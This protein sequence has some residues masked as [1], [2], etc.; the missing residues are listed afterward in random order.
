MSDH[1]IPDSK[2]PQQTIPEIDEIE[3]VLRTYRPAP[4]PHLYTRIA[5]A[6]WMKPEVAAP[7]HRANIRQRVTY[8]WA[9]AFLAVLLVC[10]FMLFTSP[11]RSLA[12]SIT[13]FFQVAPSDRETEVVSLTPFPT[14]N[15]GYPYN[16]YT[17]NITQAELLAGFK[18][19]Q[20]ADLPSNAWVF[21]GAR[22]DPESQGVILFYTLPALDSTPSNP[23]E[24]IYLYASEQRG[25]FN[26]EW[27]QCPNGTITQVKVNSWPAEL[28]DGAVW[29]TYTQ[30]TPGVTR[31]WVCERT[32]PG[33]AMT[34]R[35]QETD[36]K[37]EISVDQFAENTSVW[38][39]PS[40]LVNIASHLK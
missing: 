13:R 16:L 36:L 10:A 15:P 26:Q 21:H 5:A 6:A 28:A 24:D 30:P 35:W 22:Y 23:K 1:L 14:P 17:L 3:A 11:G 25:E 39:S 27:K 18:V 37:Y 9:F 34:L 40:D 33:T 4:D 20:L 8:R 38:L 2:S 32:D 12:Q 19:K 7:N 31:E 29:S